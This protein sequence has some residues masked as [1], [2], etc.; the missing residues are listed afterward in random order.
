MLSPHLLPPHP[1][2]IS[3]PNTLPLSRSRSA[4]LDQNHRTSVVPSKAHVSSC[5]FPRPHLPGLYPS[6]A[7]RVSTASSTRR[8]TPL[9]PHCPP[10]LL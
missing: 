10:L 7:A 5:P 3:S 2:S 9:Q 1:D 4:G 6:Q 8:P